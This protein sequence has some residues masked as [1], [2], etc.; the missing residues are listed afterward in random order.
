[1][2]G[3]HIE[4]NR[5]EVPHP[6]RAVVHP[7]EPALELPFRAFVDMQQGLRGELNKPFTLGPRPINR[8]PTAA[9]M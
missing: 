2:L 1:V 8:I 6:D 4:M 7:N 3:A 5:F 9:G